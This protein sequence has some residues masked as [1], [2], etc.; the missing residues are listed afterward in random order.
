MALGVLQLGLPYILYG[1][2]IRHVSAIEGILLPALEPV[3]NPLWVFIF[4]H[5]RPGAWSMAGALLV[6]GAV[7]ARGLLGLRGGKATQN[8]AR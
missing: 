4:L 3:L 6:L 7:S 5:E 1:I 2:A 8:Q